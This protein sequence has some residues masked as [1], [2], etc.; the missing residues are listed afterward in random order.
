MPRRRFGNHIQLQLLLSYVTSRPH[1]TPPTGQSLSPAPE[2]RA[3][4]TAAVATHVG[5]L[6]PDGR[7]ERRMPRR[8]ELVDADDGHQARHLEDHV[9]ALPGGHARTCARAVRA[10]L[11]SKHSSKP[12]E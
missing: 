8:V 2:E 11:A 6:L 3:P 7:A 1:R 5:E 10:E 9:D 12:L 4:L